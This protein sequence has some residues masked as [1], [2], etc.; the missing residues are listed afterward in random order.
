MKG[1]SGIADMPKFNNNIWEN[2]YWYMASNK[3]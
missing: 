2:S 1:K 3:T